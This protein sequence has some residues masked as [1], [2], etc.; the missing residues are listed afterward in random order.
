M[1]VI[2]EKTLSSVPTT[3]EPE[4]ADHL[5]VL[6][7]DGI[8]IS[9]TPGRP[10]NLADYEVFKATEAGDAAYVFLEIELPRDQVVTIGMSPDFW[11][12][13]WVNGEAVFED[14]I[15]GG[16]FPPSIA[17]YQ[18]DVELREG[19]NVLAVRFI[20]GRAS[21]QLALGGPNFRNREWTRPA[22]RR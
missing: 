19:T 3:K 18:V 11:L 16:S 10:V 2:D 14:T 17:D 9:A 4:P 7:L 20:R 5:A 15:E 6:R 8:R 1:S 12:D 13:A 21:A 22:G